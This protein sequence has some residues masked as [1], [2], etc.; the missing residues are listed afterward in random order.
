MVVYFK[1]VF[2]IMLAYT[3]IYAIQFDLNRHLFI[4]FFMQVMQVIP[5]SLAYGDIFLQRSQS[6]F[7]D[8]DRWRRAGSLYS[9]CRYLYN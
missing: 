7:E 3:Y 5:Y 2:Y 9:I 1:P 4:W 6:Y 8:I